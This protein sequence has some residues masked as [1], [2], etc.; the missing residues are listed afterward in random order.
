M[1]AVRVADVFR[2]EKLCETILRGSPCPPCLR[3]SG[4]KVKSLV[5]SEQDHG[6]REYSRRV[7]QQTKRARVVRRFQAVRS[8]Q[9]F[10]G[11]N[12]RRPLRRRQRALQKLRGG[13]DQH[14]ASHL[15]GVRAREQPCDQ[16]SPG[17][18]DKNI[19]APVPLMRLT[20]HADPQRPVVLWS[21]V[22][23]A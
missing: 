15:V 16:T 6:D 13:V 19:G 12:V 5:R 18:P 10:R 22:L 2:I 11:I 3:S 23:Q 20:Q 21:A 9:L 17:V 7:M 1:A 14:Q 8:D 4:T